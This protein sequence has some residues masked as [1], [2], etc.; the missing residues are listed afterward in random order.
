MSLL[1]PNPGKDNDYDNEKD[2]E[3]EDDDGVRN[4][5]WAWESGEVIGLERR[6]PVIEVIGGGDGLG[7]ELDSHTGV[8]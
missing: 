3:D 4:W 5:A 6:E 7:R 2:D 1:S 8:L